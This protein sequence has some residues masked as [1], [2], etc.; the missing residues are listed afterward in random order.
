[1]RGHSSLE[2]IHLFACGQPTAPRIGDLR[3]S[4]TLWYRASCYDGERDRSYGPAERLAGWLGLLRAVWRNANT[5]L[6]PDG[7][8]VHK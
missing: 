5:E 6:N 2:R 7:I 1:M 4:Y 3:S 8:N